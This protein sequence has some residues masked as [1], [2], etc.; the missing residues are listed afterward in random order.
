MKIFEIIFEPF[1]VTVLPSLRLCQGEL[2]SD[3]VCYVESYD[4][5]KSMDC[6]AEFASANRLCFLANESAFWEKFEDW[7]LA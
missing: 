5:V 7:Q 4:D 2:L 3:N 1:S 6:V